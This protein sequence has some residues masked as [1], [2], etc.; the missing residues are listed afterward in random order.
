MLRGC[1]CG[2]SPD[3]GGCPAGPSA[4]PA[5]AHETR[6]VQKPTEYPAFCTSGESGGPEGPGELSVTAEVHTVADDEV[7]VFDGDDWTRIEGLD[8]DHEYTVL[9]ETFRTLPRPPGERLATFATVNDVHFGEVECGL[10]EG[11]EIGPVLR[12]DPGQPPYPDMMNRAAVSEIA[13]VRPPVDPVISK[14]DLTTHGT[15]EE[16][17]LFLD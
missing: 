11:M 12:A 1:R 6:D 17:Q 16:H 8:P 3:A 13:A 2:G 14:G 9:G 5:A 7:V 15:P 4:P 10:I